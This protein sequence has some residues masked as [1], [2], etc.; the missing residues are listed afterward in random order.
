MLIDELNYDV[1]CNLINIFS[2]V[3]K[4]FEYTKDREKFKNIIHSK[5][6]FI[7]RNIYLKLISNKLKERLDKIYLNLVNQ[8]IKIIPIIS[9]KYPKNLLN[10]YNPP[11]AIF[12]YGDVI[13]NNKKIVYV[14]DENLSDFGKKVY[15]YFNYYIKNKMFMIGNT[16]QCD[17]L[18]KND[19]I[20]DENYVN[21]LQESSL[22]IP[23]NNIINNIILGIIDYLLIIEAKYNKD[24]KDI[25]SF[26]LENGK[27]ILVVP[28][29]IFNKNHYFS[30]YLIQEG[31][32]VLLNKYDLDKFI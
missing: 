8:N 23:N 32:T 2:D 3:R 17:I 20:F 25:V 13:F 9:D 12:I 21:R 22:L 24:T 28:G 7:P 1:Y 5:K 10:I 15:K 26:I 4:L 19:N 6:K 27:E 18:I 16:K 14:Y 11:L 31:A 29:N 30:N